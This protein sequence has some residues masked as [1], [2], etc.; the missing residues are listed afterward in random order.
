MNDAMEKLK[1]ILS[2]QRGAWC[3]ACG[4]NFVNLKCLNGVTPDNARSCIC[5]QCGHI[6]AYNRGKLRDLTI[7]EKIRRFWTQPASPEDRKT[8][9]SR[10]DIIKK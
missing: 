2:G 9:E 3:T 8:G 1:R 7:S 10:N 5:E 6:M 4:A